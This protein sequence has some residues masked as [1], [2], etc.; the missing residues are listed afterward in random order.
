MSENTQDIN[1]IADHLFRENSGMMVAVLTRIFG[2]QHID[3]IMDIV[4]DAFEAALIKWKYT[5]VPDNPSG[6]L[7][8]VAKNKAINTFQRESKVTLIEPSVFVKNIDGSFESKI[9]HFFLPNETVDSQLRLLLT[10]CHPDFSDKNQV[11]LTLNILCGFG[12]TEIASAL[13]MKNEAAKKA[14]SRSKA[15]LKRKE[16]ILRTPLLLQYEKR[17][18]IVHTILYLMYNEGYKTTRSDQ[19]INHD[20][21]YESI[22]LAKLLL[23]KDVALKNESHALLAL[24]FFNLARF[25]S[26]TTA[27]G[28]II[29]LAEQDRKKWN[30]AFIEEGY[31]YLNNATEDQTISR[32]HLE[33]LI[34]SLHCAAKS[35]EKTDWKTIVYLYEQLEIITPSPLITLN[36]IVAKSYLCDPLNRLEELSELKNQAEMHKHYLLHAAEGDLLKRGGKNQLAIIAF[37]N[38]LKLATSPLD[39]QFLNKK[40]AECQ[41][42]NNV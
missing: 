30:K 38:A 35:F 7:M 39:K 29:A 8:K 16:N 18:Q 23:R 15:Q 19:I 25:P 17:I 20:L 42:A 33:S 32:Y 27:A 3:R 6:W 11:I 4:H 31:F 41:T 22:R 40:I 28:E 21:C 9:D 14:L 26:R 12:V 37:T 34:A 10:C 1:A 5:G 24:M 13:Q 2:L 36:K